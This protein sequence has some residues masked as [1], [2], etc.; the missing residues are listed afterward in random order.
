MS[1]AYI[2][3]RENWKEKKIQEICK[4]YSIRI[5]LDIL[6]NVENITRDRK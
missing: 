2:V 5:N 4:L 6:R 1:Y 3:C